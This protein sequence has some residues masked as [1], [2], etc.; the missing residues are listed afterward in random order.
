MGRS[1]IKDILPELIL[2]YIGIWGM[3]EAF[4]SA[5]DMRLFNGFHSCVF[6]LPGITV[7]FLIKNSKISIRLR[8]G[9]ALLAGL[10]LTGF[11]LKSF[12]KYSAFGTV[13][14]MKIGLEFQKALPPDLF[15]GY[16]GFVF[17]FV[18]CFALA[19]ELKIISFLTVLIPFAA[20]VLCGGIPSSFSGV[21]LIIFVL[22]ESIVDKTET[23]LRY[24]YP[25]TVGVTVLVLY[26]FVSLLVPETGYEKGSNILADLIDNAGNTDTQSMD[27]AFGGIGE[28]RLGEYDTISFSDKKIFKLKTGVTGT[29]YLRGMT[30]NVYTGNSWEDFDQRYSDTYASLFNRTLC[31]VDAYSQSSKVL[32]V[33]EN[34]PELS[35]WFFGNESAFYSDVRFMRYRVEYETNNDVYWYLPY[36]NIYTVSTK[37]GIDGYP[38]GCTSRLIDDGQYVSGRLDYDGFKERLAAYSGDN[39]SLISY[40]EW[41]QKYRDFVYK[42]Y[43]GE[44]DKKGSYIETISYELPEFENT[45]R[46]EDKFIF[47]QKLKKYF[48]ENYTYTLSPGRL[49]DGDDFVESFLIDKKYGYCTSFASAAVVILRREGIPARYVQGYSVNVSKQSSS[50]TEQIEQIRQRGGYTVKDNYTQYTVEVTDR[51]AHAWVEIYIDGYGWLPFEFTPGYSSASDIQKHHVSVNK[52]EGENVISEEKNE[53][54][55]TSGGLIAEN[56]TQTKSSYNSIREYMADN[57]SGVVDFSI[58]FPILFRHFLKFLKICIYLFLLLCVVFVCILIPSE[59]ERRKIARFLQFDMSKTPKQDN[60]QIIEIYRYIQKLS[61]FL[62]VKQ[63]DD[64][65]GADFVRCLEQKYDFFKETGVEAIIYA[66]EKISYGHGNI[67]RD[68]MKKAVDAAAAVR[69]KTFERQNR[70]GKLLFRFVWHLY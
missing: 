58:V 27:T 21:L 43:T 67:G 47:A 5:F 32:S 33:I 54:E 12:L 53:G 56:E 51:S 19:Q 9:A 57:S 15:L 69:L 68:E 2:I 34:N 7:Y 37:S 20:A 18:L 39:K 3:T 38:V 25:L 35:E 16:V 6:G 55:E 36:G 11:I 52:N 45:G 42:F 61:R 64:M 14:K 66:I 29:V 59:I 49:N 46:E 13:N 17:T 4:L 70:I 50:E 44:Y 24:F 30:G 1:D 65:T 10:L 40:R 26:I 28:G 23:S 8:I 31:D 60:E 41:E 62:G 22:C 63:T 48:E